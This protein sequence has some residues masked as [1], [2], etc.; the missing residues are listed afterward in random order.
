[1]IQ[2]LR[3]A[4]RITFA[5]LTAALPAVFVAGLTA[6]RPQA[7]AERVSDR[8]SLVLASGTEVVADA[9]DL[10]GTAVDAPDPLVYWSER[11]P[12]RDSLPAN[13]RLLDSL[14]FAR[15]AHLQ[16]P[17]GAGRGYLI[18]YSLAWRKVVASAPAP[19]EMP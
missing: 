3:R 6:R 15:R 13:A 4:H 11:S 8:I 17:A 14:A 1:M 5:L 2:P 18:L 12:A 9:R 16:V 10:W 19:K 7:P